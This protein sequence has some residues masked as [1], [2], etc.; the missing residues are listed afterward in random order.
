M[1][2]NDSQLSNDDNCAFGHERYTICNVCGLYFV[3]KDLPFSEEA[4]S[5]ITKG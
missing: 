4:N 3:I 5:I 2:N 1:K